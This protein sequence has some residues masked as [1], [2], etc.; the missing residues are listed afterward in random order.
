MSSLMNKHIV[1]T[2]LILIYGLD[3]ICLL[4][5]QDALQEHVTMSRF[6]A[7]MQKLITI[8]ITVLGQNNAD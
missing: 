8:T 6:Y 5:Q 7:L 2:V 4:S 1:Q 3:P